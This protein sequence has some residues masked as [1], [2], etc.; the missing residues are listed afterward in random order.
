MIIKLMGHGM[1]KGMG[2][3]GG[4]MGWRGGQRRWRD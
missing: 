3:G 4:E 2:H 1:V